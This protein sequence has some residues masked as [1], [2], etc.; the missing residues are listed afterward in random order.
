MVYDIERDHIQE[1]RE[2]LKVMTVEMEWIT[3]ETSNFF[4][5]NIQYHNSVPV[6]C[7]EVSNE[8]RLFRLRFIHYC[9]LLRFI[10]FYLITEQYIVFLEK[11][12]C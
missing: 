6:L 8:Y 3:L 4:W 1:V 7:K 9:L 10:Y 5:I 12:N 2:I 11:I